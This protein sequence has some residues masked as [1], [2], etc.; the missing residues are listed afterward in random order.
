MMT[1]EIPWKNVAINDIITTVGY[2]KKQI[3]LPTK[4][5]SLILSILKSCLSLDKNSRPTFKEIVGQLQQRNKGAL[6]TKKSKLF[7]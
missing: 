6:V 3:P 4:G 7:Y 1:G 2:E 5:N